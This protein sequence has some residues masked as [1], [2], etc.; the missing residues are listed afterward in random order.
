[1]TISP[2]VQQL[3]NQSMQAVESLS[4]ERAALMT[5]FYQQDLGLLSTP[6]QRAMSF[7]YL[8][9][10][11]TLYLNV[12]ELIVGE[13]GHAPKAAP[14]FPELCTHSLDD[15]DI[16]NSREKTA[17]KVT[18]DARKTYE[19]TVIPFWKGRSMREKLFAEMTPEW[20]EAYD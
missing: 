6:V 10:H 3:R 9:E 18:P 19:E 8:M 11:R 7:A 20:K 12:G 14:T 4:V 17:F 15:L 1:M 2:R 13:K 16:L 5:A